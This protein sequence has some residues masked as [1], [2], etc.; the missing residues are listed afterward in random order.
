[1]ELPNSDKCRVPEGKITG[2]LLSLAHE[3]GR[4]KAAFF[5]RF[6]FTPSDW[7]VLAT[8]LKE[9]ASQHD[10]VRVEESPFGKRYIIEGHIQT[11]D[12]RAPSIRSVWFIENGT[13]IPRLVTAYP[14]R[15]K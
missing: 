15:R 10:V 4:T 13:D 3:D 11:P 9:H 1:M 14:L 2:Y 8:A 12:G 6:G 5:L 7:I